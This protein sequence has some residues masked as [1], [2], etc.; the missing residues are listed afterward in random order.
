MPFR[1]VIES[2]REVWSAGT[3]EYRGSAAEEDTPRKPGTEHRER[4]TIGRRKGPQTSAGLRHWRHRISSLEHGEALG[5]ASTVQQ[6]PRV[7]T[8]GL[9]EIQPDLL[10]AVGISGHT[11]AGAPAAS[12]LGWSSGRGRGTV[13]SDRGAVFEYYGLKAAEAEGF[14]GALLNLKATPAAN[15]ERTMTTS[16]T[17]LTAK[18]VS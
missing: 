4:A 16:I 7:P 1:R 18:G 15:G 12:V 11:G 5:S 2:E 13:R 8:P 17:T 3:V 9:L 6:G 10:V 14:V